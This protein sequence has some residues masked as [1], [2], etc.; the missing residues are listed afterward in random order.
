[1]EKKLVLKLKRDKEIKD[2]MVLQTEDKKYDVAY[3]EEGYILLNIFELIGID[4]NEIDK[5]ETTTSLNCLV[6]LISKG[7]SIRV[8]ESE[9]GYNL[10]V[11]R[12]KC[13]MNFTA[14]K[15]QG[16]AKVMIDAENWSQ[17]LLE[18]IQNC[19]T[20]RNI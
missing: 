11:S 2:L 15:E 13:S 12:D 8:D 14:T 10:I 17:T 6:K 16:F 9:K 4:F 7:F 19:C 1:M 5:I 3:F 18:E 20:I